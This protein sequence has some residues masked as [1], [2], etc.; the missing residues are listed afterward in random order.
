MP[1]GICHWTVHDVAL[2]VYILEFGFIISNF[3]NSYISIRRETTPI[4]PSAWIMVLLHSRVGPHL[5]VIPNKHT[6]IRGAP[7]TT[8]ASFQRWTMTKVEVFKNKICFSNTQKYFCNLYT[9]FIQ[10]HSS[11][12]LIH[13]DCPEQV[14][15]S[16]C[17]WKLICRVG[18]DTMNF[19]IAHNWVFLDNSTRRE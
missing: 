13:K 16:W 12:K 1:R 2:Y 8:T 15:D 11:R 4:L 7:T 18:Q 6:K 17:L 14:G 19:N 10:N 9:P 5:Y 3:V